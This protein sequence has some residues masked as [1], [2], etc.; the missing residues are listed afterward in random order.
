MICDNLK[1]CLQT[2]YHIQNPEDDQVHDFGIYLID[3]ILNQA[4]KSL[5][6]FRDMPQITGYW[7][8]IVGN[9]FVAEQRA[10]DPPAK[11]ARATENIARLNPGQKLV[12]DQILASVLRSDSQ[13]RPQGR[14]SFVHGPGGTGKSFT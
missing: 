14:P 5:D 12:H 4:G 3:K 1:Y 11:L 7:E 13:G 2:T 9:Q 10:Y 6:Q 8:E